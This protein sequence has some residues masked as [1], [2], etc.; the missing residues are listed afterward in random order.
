MSFAYVGL[1]DKLAESLKWAPGHEQIEKIKIE[2]KRLLKEA[3]TIARRKA[4]EMGKEEGIK[5]GFKDGN[6]VGKMEGIEIGLEKGKVIGFE[7]GKNVGKVEGI[8]IGEKNKTIEM[9][10]TMLLKGASYK[11]IFD[12]TGLSKSE[13]SELS[14]AWK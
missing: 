13:I 7:E 14:K 5:I 11:E 10:K 4:L 6:D 12:L 9:A 3:V 2:H 1:M 8:E